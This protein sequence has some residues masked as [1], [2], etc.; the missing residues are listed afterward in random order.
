M[1][2]FFSAAKVL[3]LGDSHSTFFWMDNLLDGKG[4]RCLA[5]A[6]FATVPKRRRGISV[7]KVLHDR[8]WV[9]TYHW[10]AH[11]ETVTEFIS[12]WN[13]VEQVHLSPGVPDTFKWRFTADGAY[14]S[15]SAYGAMFLG[16]SRPL[17]AKEIWK[18]SAPSCVKFFFWL[19]LHGRCWT[20]HRRHQHGLQDNDACIHCDQAVETM[21]HIILGCVYSREVWASCLRRFLLHDLVAIQEEGVMLWWISSRSACP[22][23]SA[24]G[25][26][27]CSS[28]LVGFCGRK[29]TQEPSTE[30]HRRRRSCWRPLSRR[31]PCGAPLGSSSWW[32]WMLGVIPP[33]LSVALGRSIRCC[34]ITT[35]CEFSGYR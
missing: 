34:V 30:L 3:A 20:A 35:A 4:I 26:T 16:S 21:D 23:T 12:L 5:L 28:L 24:E 8:V 32:R 29:G 22:R 11:H 18:T 6:V 31:S 14:S 15:S 7:A 9:L 33:S 2:A 1:A 19:V 13:T 10:A 25:S 17:G 27:H